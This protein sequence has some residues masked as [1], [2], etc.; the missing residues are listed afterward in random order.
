M[1][2][3]PSN[4]EQDC[5]LK[6]TIVWCAWSITYIVVVVFVCDNTI[7]LQNVVSTYPFLFFPYS[8]ISKPHIGI[9]SADIVKHKIQYD[10]VNI[11][12]FSTFCRIHTEVSKG[13]NTFY[14]FFEVQLATMCGLE[15]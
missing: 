15:W 10:A 5:S 13:L 4:C 9:I 2:I 12:F 6:Y 14:I 1:G 7:F 3:A 8:Q 11:L